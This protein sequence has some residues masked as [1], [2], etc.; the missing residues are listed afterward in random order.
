MLIRCLL[1]SSCIIKGSIVVLMAY[2]DFGAKVLFV[3]FLSVMAA[4]EAEGHW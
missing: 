1:I 4:L 2:G 3:S